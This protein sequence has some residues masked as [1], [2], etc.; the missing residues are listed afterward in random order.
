MM[1]KLFD[2]GIK[3]RLKFIDAKT[4]KFLLYAN[5]SGVP[6]TAQFSNLVKINSGNS[7][8]NF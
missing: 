1:R 7:C 8:F 4:S 5:I 2:S 3:I 6:N